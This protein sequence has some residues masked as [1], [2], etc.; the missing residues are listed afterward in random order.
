[1]KSKL[2]M[3]V[4]ISIVFSGLVALFVFTRST[5]V[6]SKRAGLK[7]VTGYQADLGGTLFDPQFIRYLSS[8]SPEWAQVLGISAQGNE[9]DVESLVKASERF[10]IVPSINPRIMTIYVENYSGVE[11]LAPLAQLKDLAN[12]YIIKSMED[13]NLKKEQLVEKWTS[14]SKKIDSFKNNVLAH[15]YFERASILSRDHLILESK[16]L[17]S[18]MGG[19]DSKKKNAFFAFIGT[20]F[21]CLS[22][23]TVVVFSKRRSPG[24]S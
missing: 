11:L 9:D 1:M 24:L 17:P 14:E 4:C 20:L 21:I 18:A 10:F 6:K 16:I 15:V 22:V 19:G 5:E 7:V 12:S 3:G 23:L 8:A 13:R 2:I